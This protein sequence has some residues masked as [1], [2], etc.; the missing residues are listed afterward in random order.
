MQSS[1]SSGTSTHDQNSSNV[2]G[3]SH[4][5]KTL[6]KSF[7]KKFATF[8]SFMSSRRRAQSKLSQSSINMSDDGSTTISQSSSIEVSDESSNYVQ[9]L[10]QLKETGHVLT[11]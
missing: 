8:G 9:V 6:K 1:I 10:L 7:S 11:S 4:Q 3:E 5:K 2:D